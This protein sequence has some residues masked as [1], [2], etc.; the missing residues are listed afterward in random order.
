MS[1]PSLRPEHEMSGRTI[2]C[3]N[4]GSRAANDVH[5]N[6][7]WNCTCSLCGRTY[8]LLGSRLRGSRMRLQF[9]VCSRNCLKDLVRVARKL[10]ET[11]PHLYQE[12]LTEVQS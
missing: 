5:G 8:V 4:V 9:D 7:Q 10:Q 11:D 12:F 1:G 2:G 6:A 3:L